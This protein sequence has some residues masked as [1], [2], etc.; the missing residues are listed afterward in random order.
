MTVE[1][2]IQVENSQKCQ[3]FE[4]S[5]MAI[6]FSSM[7]TDVYKEE[8]LLSTEAAVGAVGG[9]LGLFLGWSFYGLVVDLLDNW[10]SLVKIFV[11]VNVLCAFLGLIGI[12]IIFGTDFFIDRIGI[13]LIHFFEH[14]ATI[15]IFKVS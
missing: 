14:F 12:E 7:A 10:K 11:V 2:K 5:M 4:A 1:Y 13:E 8:L 9:S 3:P 15:E 6:S